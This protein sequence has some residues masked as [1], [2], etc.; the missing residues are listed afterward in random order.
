[1]SIRTLH[2]LT[3]PERK[4]HAEKTGGYNFFPPKWRKITEKEFAQ[5]RHFAFEPA[6]TEYRQMMRP[7]G[8]TDTS[9]DT[10]AVS[11]HLHWQANGIGFAIVADY[12]EGTV[13]F[14]TF[15]ETP[16]GFVEIFDS[17][18]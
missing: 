10:P 17:S 18:D 1:M 12:W 9:K 15:G 11:A 5:S 13:G 4:A 16:A 2:D 3:M 6:L 8:E 14:Y 7:F